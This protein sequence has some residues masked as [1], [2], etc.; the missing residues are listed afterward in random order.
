MAALTKCPSCDNEVSTKAAA[1]PKCGHQFKTPG[2]FNIKDR[3]DP[4]VRLRHHPRPSSA[5][6]LARRDKPAM[7]PGK[8]RA[9]VASA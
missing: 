7:K 1:C 4:R 6:G 3:S 9:A 8:P 5:H 2:G